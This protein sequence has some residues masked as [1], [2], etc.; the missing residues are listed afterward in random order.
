MCVATID[1]TN[2]NVHLC[3]IAFDTGPTERTE[4]FGPG[5]PWPGRRW[6]QHIG[7]GTLA[8]NVSPQKK[9]P[10]LCG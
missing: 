3:Y 1:I 10:T 2:K 9:L 4:V 7:Y 5:L 8:A 6:F